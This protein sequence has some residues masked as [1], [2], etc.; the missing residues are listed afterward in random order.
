MGAWLASE[1][2]SFT[3]LVL[4]FLFLLHQPPS[5]PTK[6][7]QGPLPASPCV[8]KM[9][10]ARGRRKGEERN[11]TERQARATHMVECCTPSVS[12]RLLQGRVNPFFAKEKA[13]AQGYEVTLGWRCRQG[14]QSGS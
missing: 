6:V 13:E 14:T 12:P 11:V 3:L 4:R 2:C 9:R 10:M 5:D 8:N 1:G 7:R